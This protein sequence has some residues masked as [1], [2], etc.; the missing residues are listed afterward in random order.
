MKIKA[1][2]LGQDTRS[3]VAMIRLAALGAGVF[4]CGS[5]WA[6]SDLYIRDTP[7]DTGAE[8][9]AGGDM[10]V[11]ED[12][13]VR[14][15]PDPAWQPYPFN[16]ASPP[17]TPA[18]HQ[19]PEYRDPKYS[20]PNYIYVRVRNRGGAAS[21]G[22]ER[23]R[24][25]WAKASTGLSWPAQWVDY[26]TTMPGCNARVFGMEITK[27][28][29]N[30]ATATPAER[31]AYRDAIIA[32][33]TTPAYQFPDRSYWHKQDQ[34]HESAPAG[35]AHF[36][37]P[38]L[39]WHREYVNRYELLLRE[40]NPL[41]TLLYW[42]WTVN[43]SGPGG[44]FNYFTTTFMGVSGAGGGAS[45]GAPF[46][47][48]AA[49]LDGAITRAFNWAGG[50]IPASDASILTPAS[51]SGA[52]GLRN[53][54]ESTAHG[55]AHLRIGGDQNGFNGAAEDPW[56]FLIHADADRLFAQWQRSDLT[57]ARLD[58]SAVYGADGG[59]S[60]INNNLPPWDGS[61]VLNNDTLVNAPIRPW[62]AGDG[63]IVNKNAKHRSI[64]APPIYDVAP[65]R[66]P[67]LAPGQAVVLEIPWYPP[68]PGD[69]AC[70]G[71][72]GHHC[73][74]ARIETSTNAPFGMTTV[75]G[76]DVGVNTCNNNNIAWKNLTV[77][78]N[79][80]GAMALSS[81]LVR[82]IH[83]KFNLAT[84]RFR[85]LG[86]F[87]P[88]FSDFGRPFFQLPK[89]IFARWRQAGGGLKGIELI[90]ENRFQLFGDT[91]EI[92]GIPMNRE[93]TFS[94]DLQFELGPNY[95]PIEGRDIAFD[96]QQLGSPED[97][98]GFVGGVRFQI[99]ISK[100]TFVKR[101]ADWRYLDGG[102]IADKQWTSA[103]YDDSKWALRQAG[104]GYGGDQTTTIRP[105]GRG[106]GGLAAY[107]RR[108]FQTRGVGITRDTWLRLRA[109][110]GVVVY[111]N[112]REVMRRNLPQGEISPETPALNEVTGIAGEIFLQIPIETA[113]TLLVEG[114]NIIAAEVHAA[115]KADTD[116]YFDLEFC[117]NLAARSVPPEVRIRRPLNGERFLPTETIGVSADAMDTD[118]KIASVRFTVDGEL[119]GTATAPPYRTELS[120]LKIGRH[121]VAAF[122]TDDDGLTAEEVVDVIIEQ[123]L[124]PIVEFSTPQQ[125]QRFLAS[126]PVTL[127]AN[128]ED[129]GGSIAQVDFLVRTGHGFAVEDDFKLVGSSTKPPY[130]V[131]VR[132]LNPGHYM[133]IA[134]ATDNSG[135][136][137]DAPSLHFEITGL[138]APEL[139]IVPMAPGQVMLTWNSPGAAL[140]YTEVLPGA[141][142]TTIQNAAS[143]LHETVGGKARFY[144]LRIQP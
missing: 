15:N 130:G 94:L 89:E 106:E 86:T 61:S 134:R 100:L 73:L 33:G 57:G 93:E 4:A 14:T 38:F 83:E 139:R 77:V 74:L 137:G 10:Y 64:V 19:N 133:A 99:D 60:V 11:S 26:A 126:E 9:C 12:I 113:R 40:A 78:D 135:V 79:F 21:T 128:A 144:R 55:R 39:P 97:P 36:A 114:E 37:A 23:L 62:T 51:Y 46:G 81:L 96:I 35:I 120:G 76:P 103:K 118:G 24:V 121:R 95:Q 116:L 132:G 68:N 108:S 28:R 1:T 17:W 124:A 29:K 32:I 52:S 70:F 138:V 66:I 91:A 129:R 31:E 45:V 42:D 41:V 80:P 105:V 115:S 63:Y 50:A 25:Y 72:P 58:P 136:T 49:P 84:I 104:L 69:Y 16:A 44:G 85:N 141:R 2:S 59:I 3:L 92:T 90:G 54:M 75:E 101:G 47:S 87:A 142:W 7:S 56:F 18:A 82:N 67:I 109:S 6:Q 140:E 27:P 131:E 53:N 5:L 111:L 30:A 107:F 119:V 123:N 71:D 122:A 110:D 98:D 43:P 8:P 48:L 102:Q 127:G 13:W 88:K 65:L 22:N 34:I 20:T 117:A 112:G 125:Y 143:P